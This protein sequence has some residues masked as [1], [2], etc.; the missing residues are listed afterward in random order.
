MARCLH[1]TVVLGAP[2]PR[3]V[4]DSAPQKEGLSREKCEQSCGCYGSCFVVFGIRVSADRVQRRKGARIQCEFFD[5]DQQQR[6]SRSEHWYERFVSGV[7]LGPRQRR[8]E[9][10]SKW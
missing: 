10:G 2:F 8:G 7:D 4:L 3:M 5:R 9:L 1:L 6:P